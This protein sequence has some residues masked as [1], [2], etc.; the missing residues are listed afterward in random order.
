M[1]ISPNELDRD[2]WFVTRA[3]DFMGSFFTNRF[4][5]SGADVRSF[6][7]YNTFGWCG[8]LTQLAVGVHSDC[9]S[10]ATFEYESTVILPITVERKLYKHICQGGY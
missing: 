7:H 3:N 8:R 9:F 6:V 10:R 4:V 1:G 2:G 5:E